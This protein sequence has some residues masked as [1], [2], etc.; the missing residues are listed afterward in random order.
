LPPEIG[1]QPKQSFYFPIEESLGPTYEDLVREVLSPEA[2]RRRGILE[3][4]WVEGLLACGSKRELVHSK[5]LFAAVALE[6]WL[7]EVVDPSPPMPPPSLAP[8]SNS[9]LTVS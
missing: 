4:A 2:V 9:Q 1:R 6:I 5:R 7:R 3:P 8:S